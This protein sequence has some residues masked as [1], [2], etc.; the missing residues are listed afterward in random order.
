MEGSELSQSS[1]S[2]RRRKSQ[3]SLRS[4][5]ERTLML[6]TQERQKVDRDAQL[7]K[8]RIALLRAEEE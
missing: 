7:L 6:A 4:E 5:K 2:R 8:N 3:P 1:K